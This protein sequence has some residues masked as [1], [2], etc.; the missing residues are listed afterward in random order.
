MSS[1]NA[2]IKM[3]YSDC[4]VIPDLFHKM[5]VNFLKISYIKSS[6]ISNTT[7][8]PTLV[9]HGKPL[10]DIW[11]KMLFL[12]NLLQFEVTQTLVTLFISSAVEASQWRKHVDK[13]C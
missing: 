10:R 4:I 11:G 8:P 9:L 3:E 5:Y 1:K 2:N 12:Q 13:Q 6:A 7:R